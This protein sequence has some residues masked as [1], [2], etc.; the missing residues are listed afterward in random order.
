MNRERNLVIQCKRSLILFAGA[1]LLGAAGWVE[2]EINR[3]TTNGPAGGDI[4]ALAIDPSSPAILY[5]G[6]SL[7]V[8]KSTNGGESWSPINTG[9]T[10]YPVLPV[11]RALAIDPSAPATLY[12]GTFFTGVFKSTNGGGSWSAINAGL[13]AT[14][15]LA[16]EPSTLRRRLRSTP[17]RRAASSRA[18]TAGRAGRL[19]TPA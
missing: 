11:F 9:L 14:G 4:L 1:L 17:A 2:A 5:A 8:F 13:T 3:W 19:S 6:T 18:T 10:L 15:V 7:G 12:A 16:L